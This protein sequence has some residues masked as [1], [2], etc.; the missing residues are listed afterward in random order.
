MKLLWQCSVAMPSIVV[1]LKQFYERFSAYTH[2]NVHR[3]NM[4][5]G[6]M[7]IEIDTPISV[8]VV[9]PTTWE[10][11]HSPRALPSGFALG[12]WWASQVVGD[13]TMTSIL[14]SIPITDDSA[15]RFIVPVRDM[16]TV[17]CVSTIHNVPDSF[18]ESVLSQMARFMGPT[19]CQFG[20]DRTQVGPMLAP[21]TLLSGICLTV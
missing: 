20:A 15:V 17:V 6:I 14:V 19:W 13:T 9:S 12:L 3:F 10:A 16:T 21:W 1:V 11:H 2:P 5:W 4:L 8:I 18:P 7:I